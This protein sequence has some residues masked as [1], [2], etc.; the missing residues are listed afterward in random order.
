MNQSKTKPPFLIQTFQKRK[1][2]KKMSNKGIQSYIY[3]LSVWRH[4]V[5]TLIFE[6]GN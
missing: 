4:N 3:I 1:K 5:P 6:I 2:I